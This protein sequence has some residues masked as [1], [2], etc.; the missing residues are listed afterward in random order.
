MHFAQNNSVHLI[1]SFSFDHII[2]CQS[3]RI[4]PN[5]KMLSW[6]FSLEQMLG[7][8]LQYQYLALAKFLHFE[9]WFWYSFW[10]FPIYKS[11]DEILLKCIN[12]SGSCTK[13]FS[14]CCILGI[15]YMRTWSIVQSTFSN[16]RKFFLTEW[17]IF[18]TG[19]F[20]AHSKESLDS[21]LGCGHMQA[22]S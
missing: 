21:F 6:F 22:A 3:I 8:E 18:M 15:G 13:V 9:F 20:N 11:L 1:N 2:A 19:L 17:F 14:H 12:V 16:G 7:S 4:N 10:F 5:S